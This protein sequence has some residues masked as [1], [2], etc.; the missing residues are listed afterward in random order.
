MGVVKKNKTVVRKSPRQHQCKYCYKIF[1]FPNVLKKH[2]RV[3]TG[4]RPYECDLCGNRF[5]HQNTLKNHKMCIHNC[6]REEDFTCGHCDK[7]F[8]IKERLIEH[9][10]IHTGYYP[11]RCDKCLKSFTRA[12]QL[13][14]HARSHNKQY[15]LE[16]AI[17][18]Q[19]FACR[20]VLRGH[21]KRHMGQNDYVCEVCGK[22]FLRRDG[23]T[24][25]LSSYHNNIRAFT[26]KI[27][28]KQFKGHMIQHLR[29]HRHEKP[30]ECKSCDARFV[31]RSQ[32]TVHERRHSGEKPYPC[33]VCKVSFA[34]ST[35]MKMHVRRHTGEKPFK[36]LVCTN[37]AFTQ[38]PH[39]K[40]HM[41][42]I[43]KTDKPYLCVKCNSYF[44]TKT[45]IITHEETCSP[46]QETKEFIP[47]GMALDRMR[48]LLAVLLIRISTTERLNALGFGK[49]LIDLV[50]C[51]SIENSGRCP[52]RANGQ[53]ENDLL[54]KNIEILLDWTVPKVYMD[55]FKSER[56][57]TEEILEELTS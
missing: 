23:L 48:M 44:K 6:G 19:L 18:H 17:C 5:T 49:R 26:C 4:E 33:P 54:K 43:H 40:K 51:D 56:R 46:K 52:Y 42:T 16:C 3:H 14:Q 30:Y 35:A 45:Q 1:P 39:L 57:T 34:H 29:T 24:K 12:S 10:R 21:M 13:W 20:S 28:H 50:L 55:R 37:T 32:L 53:S 8:P 38:L 11:H 22:A 36:C 31:Q 7:K 27:C 9:V 15:T 2:Y 41:L 25:H 47:P